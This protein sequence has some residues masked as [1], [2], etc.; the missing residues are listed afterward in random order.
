MLLMFNLDDCA[1]SSISELEKKVF[2]DIYDN[3]KIK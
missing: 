2:L 1:L 3:D